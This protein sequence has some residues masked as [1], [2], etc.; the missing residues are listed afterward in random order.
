MNLI[1]ASKF[2]L[3]IIILISL[4]TI[5]AFPIRGFLNEEEFTF[6]ATHWLEFAQFTGLLLAPIAGFGAAMIIS[7]QLSFSSKI[8]QLETLERS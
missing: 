3:R 1:P 2:T 5:L 7:L 8:S 6:E 4:L